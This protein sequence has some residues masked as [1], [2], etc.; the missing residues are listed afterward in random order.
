MEKFL[1]MVATEILKDKSSARQ[2]LKD[3]QKKCVVRILQ[4]EMGK[5]WSDY[6]TKKKA[7]I[8]KIKKEILHETNEK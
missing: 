2:N 8:L 6:K 4:E 7:R 5:K 3:L 1:H